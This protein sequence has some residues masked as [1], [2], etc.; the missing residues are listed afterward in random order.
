MNRMKGKLRLPALYFAGPS[1]R[2][3]PS[4]NRKNAHRYSKK[5][6][7]SLAIAMFVHGN[8]HLTRRI[9]SYYG[10]IFAGV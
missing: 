4:P 5:P 1:T 6:V 9:F 2:N 8:Y 10:D 7:I 3:W